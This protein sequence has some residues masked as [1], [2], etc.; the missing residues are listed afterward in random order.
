MMRRHERWAI[1]VLMFISCAKQAPPPGGPVDETPP[2]IVA[3]EPAPG[4]V[5]VPR[6]LHVRFRFSER[7]DHRTFADALFVTPTPPGELRF[8]WSGALVKVNFPDSLLV[9]TTYVIT[10]GTGIRDLRNNRLEASFSQ[11]FSTGD[12]IAR[13]EIHGRLFGEKVQSLLVG[14]YLIHLPKQ[15][16]PGRD[17]ADYTTQ[18]DKDG[19][20]QFRYLVP[21]LYRLFALDDKYG[22]RL[23]DRG[24]DAIGIAS[25]DVRLDAAQPRADNLY[26][27]LALEDTLRPTLTSV[28]APDNRHLEWRFDEPV[29]T[30]SG[31][32]LPHLRVLASSNG[33]PPFALLATTTYPL[34][35]SQAQSYTS[36]QTAGSYRAF[37]DG[38]IDLSGLPLDS[39]YRQVEFVATAAPDTTPPRL[40]RLLP[41]DSSR[42]VPLDAAVEATFSDLMRMD[43]TRAPFLIHDSSGAVVHGRGVWRN[44][45][46]FE[47]RPVKGWQS[48]NRY[49]VEMR[50]DS[51]FELS[52]LALVDTVR[53]RRFWA[54]NADTLGVIS[55]LVHDDLSAASGPLRLSAKQLVG[56]K[57]DR[58][59]ILPAP[60]PYEV[61]GLLPGVYQLS[62]YRDANNNGRYDFGT[63]AP[64]LPAER[65]VVAPD[66]VK[67]RARWPNEGNDI[68]L[69]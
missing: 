63:L 28:T 55:G 12:S 65:F 50:T 32:W 40:V 18:A 34:H 6:D 14:A 67:V 56:G 3:V 26:M 21:G 45:F 42:G 11:A 60:G 10:L 48:L 23:Y 1:I 4:A 64:F 49:T 16:D 41:A 33:P 29:Q 39:L 9:N 44:H 37:A 54:I 17:V 58:E 61:P 52:G 31:D 22:N 24:V 20:F 15:P 51:T 13:G 47:F 62:V 5:R 30:T 36:P 66:S 25:R 19:G 2:K 43:S 53:V 57:L 35:L 59:V 46:Q 27:R 8:D 69:P 68:T 7:I 38:V